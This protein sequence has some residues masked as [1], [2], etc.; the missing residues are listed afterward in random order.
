MD[1]AWSKVVPGVDEKKTPVYQ[2]ILVRIL[3]RS[4]F[5]CPT[6]SPE[7]SR[8]VG[9][10]IIV[11]HDHSTLNSTYVV[12]EEEAERR[13]MTKTSRLFM[14]DHRTVTLAGVFYDE[15]VVFR[16]NLHNPLHVARVPK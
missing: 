14:A 7:R 5:S 15:K 1:F 4:Q 16:C 11:R 12:R 3:E 10:L 6:V 8:Q 9:K 2:R 13:E